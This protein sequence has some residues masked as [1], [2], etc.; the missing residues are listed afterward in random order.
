MTATTRFGPNH[1]LLV[2]PDPR[3]RC[4]IRKILED[5][6]AI[7]TVK[8]IDQAREHI[9]RRHGELRLVITDSGERLPG[10]KIIALTQEFGVPVIALTAGGHMPPE[11]DFGFKDAKIVLKKPFKPQALLEAAE[12]HARGKYPP[13]VLLV[14]PED[15]TREHLIRLLS[16]NHDVLACATKEGAVKHLEENH[17][18]VKLLVSEHGDRFPHGI[19]LLGLAKR[20]KIPVI[21]MSAG[22]KVRIA[23][24]QTV[25]ADY[26]IEKP[27]SSRILLENVNEHSRAITW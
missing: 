10:H 8:T 9:I 27:V 11:K 26:F 21:L 17:G 18:T 2:E 5:S 3:V 7:R 22:D 6:F 15:D 14:E 23:Q 4:F 25:G 19:E 12:K 16:D 13:H 20:H 24:A 1:I